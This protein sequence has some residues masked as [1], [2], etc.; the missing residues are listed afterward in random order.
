ML[1]GVKKYL[2]IYVNNK[3]S[4]K[5]GNLKLTTKYKKNKLKKLFVR[6]GI[7]SIPFNINNL[8]EKAEGTP[9]LWCGL[10]STNECNHINYI[11]NILF[12]IDLNL[13]RLLYC[14]DFNFSLIDFDINKF[15]DYCYKY[16]DD[17]ECCYCLDKLNTKYEFWCCDNCK[18]LIHNKCISEWIKKNNECPLCKQ[19][20]NKIFGFY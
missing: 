15:Y 8:F 7:I 10:C 2:F 12:K 9:H 13:I 17:I 5:T 19:K 4:Y 11:Y 16:L 14:N 1:K 20:I 6:D 3:K 18:H